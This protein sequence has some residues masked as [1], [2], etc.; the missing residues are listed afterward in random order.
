MVFALQIFE[1]KQNQRKMTELTN[2]AEERTKHFNQRLTKKHEQGL[3]LLSIN[4]IKII[5]FRKET[6]QRRAFGSNEKAERKA[7][8]R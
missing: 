3:F 4:K 2:L 8:T 7:R 6:N 1:K 5:I